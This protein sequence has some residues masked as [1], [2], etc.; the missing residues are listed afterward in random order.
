MP[1]E[2]LR[3]LRRSRRGASVVSGVGTGRRPLADAAARCRADCVGPLGRL[4]VCL[5]KTR[6]E[7]PDGPDQRNWSTGCH[8]GYGRHSPRPIR[9]SAA[10]A[11]QSLPGCQEI[12]ATTHP[13]TGALRTP[14]HQGGG[15]AAGTGRRVGGGVE[16]RPPRTAP[17][18]SGVSAVGC[19][20]RGTRGR[21]AVAQGRGRWRRARQAPIEADCSPSTAV[22]T[23]PAGAQ[24]QSRIAPVPL[25]RSGNPA[26]RAGS[27]PPFAFR[28]R[29]SRESSSPSP[30]A[31]QEAARRNH[32][33]ARRQAEGCRAGGW[34]PG[35]TGPTG[36]PPRA[37]RQPIRARLGVRR[38]GRQPVQHGAVGW[39]SAIDQARPSPVVPIG[40]MKGGVG[41]PPAWA[42][43]P[44]SRRSNRRPAEGR[45]PGR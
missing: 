36:R 42:G 31:L 26:A 21:P 30:V 12:R 37:R 23:A 40:D 39:R 4:P 25:K 10:S 19:R 27:P 24:R 2:R 41:R 29:P 14:P 45:Q 17:A 44:S 32:D 43:W 7:A 35:S 33:R 13:G 3:R 1:A 16:T 34:P 8:C 20:G 5:R 6:R 15:L 18:S 11:G 38:Q 9:Q 22:T 28:H